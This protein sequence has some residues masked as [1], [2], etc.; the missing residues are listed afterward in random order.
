[1]GK[2][3]YPCSKLS[4]FLRKWAAPC[5]AIGIMATHSIICR[6]SIYKNFSLCRS[7]LTS[8]WRRQH[9][10][11]IMGR[12]N[13]EWWRNR[14]SIYM[15]SNFTFVTHSRVET[16]CLSHC[17][18]GDV[19]VNSKV[20]LSNSLLGIVTS[21]Y[22][23]KLLLEERHRTYQLWSQQCFV[24]AWCRQATSQYLSQCWPRYFPQYSVIMPQWVNP[25]VASLCYRIG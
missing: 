17:P 8:T 18:L 3:I 4:I 20:K 11:N 15:N 24:M 10:L 22:A 25:F 19:T 23:V 7:N 2:N 12:Y 21:A 9:V 14:R 16:A 6:N 13:N 1:M 5:V